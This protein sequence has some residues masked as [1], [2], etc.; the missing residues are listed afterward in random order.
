MIITGA[1]VE[2]LEFDEVKY[3]EELKT[4]FK[5][6]E[7]NVFS[8]LYIC[9]AAQAGLFYKY[10][11]PKYELEKK[12]SGI[13]LQKKLSATNPLLRG[14]D[15]YFWAPQSRYT[16]I[17]REDI[18]AC[19]DLELLAE[20]EDAGVHMAVSKDLRHVFVTGHGEYDAETLHLEYTR[21]VNKGINPEIPKNYYKGDNPS[22]MPAVTWRSHSMLFFNNWLNYCVYQET[23][24]DYIREGKK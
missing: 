11:I 10:G 17:R 8:T 6:A 14:F 9:W 4:I 15:D 16:E 2:L 18:L 24:Y 19:P 7:N 23:P 22:D 13:F 3:W 20:S 21:D 1:P 5:W 12:L